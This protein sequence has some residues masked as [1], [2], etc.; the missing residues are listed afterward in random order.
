MT[1][2]GLFITLISLLFTLSAAILRGLIVCFPVGLSPHYVA[3]F[4]AILIISQNFK[5]PHFFIEAA[6]LS[7][8]VELFSKRHRALFL[9]KAYEQGQVDPYQ[10]LIN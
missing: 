2:F 9:Y 1:I 10:R 6:T 4:R 3:T 7:S 8:E 5:S